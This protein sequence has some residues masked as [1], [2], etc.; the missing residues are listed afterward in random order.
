MVALT[1]KTMTTA[2]AQ[3]GNIGREVGEAIRSHWVLF[4]IQGLIMVVLGLMAAAEPM[5]ATLAVEIFAGWLFVISGIVGL[6]GAFTAQRVPGYWW[7]LLT[8]ALSIA[9]GAYLISRPLAGILSLTLVVGAYFAVQGITQ[10]ITAIQHRNV[11]GSWIWLVIGGVVNLFLSVIIVSGWPGTAAWT[12]G[13]LFGI[14]LFMWGVS[15]VMTAIGCRAVS[16]AP[17][18]TKAAA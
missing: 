9:A 7:S 1:E 16:D 17:Q 6:A 2:N 5:M 12:L 4:L 8:A 3:V 15:L 13:L 11:L 18:A 14:N 10:I